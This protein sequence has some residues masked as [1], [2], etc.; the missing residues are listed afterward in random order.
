MRS[1]LQAV[2]QSRRDFEGMLIACP[3]VAMRSTML[4]V[5]T[6]E[7]VLERLTLQGDAERNWH[8]SEVPR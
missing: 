4:P 3:V 2:S 5:N 1:G 6:E 7:R 8:C